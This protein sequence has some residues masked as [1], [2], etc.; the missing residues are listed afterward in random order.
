LPAGLFIVT[1]KP[2]N[3]ATNRKS[4]SAREGMKQQIMKQQHSGN[5]PQKPLS[6]K[7][8]ITKHYTITCYEK[9]FI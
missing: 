4:Q 7:T 6:G 5:K 3:H 8:I 1:K 2:V 9:D